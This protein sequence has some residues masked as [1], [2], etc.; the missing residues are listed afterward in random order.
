MSHHLDSPKARQD[1]RLDISDVYI[2]DGDAGTV[3][4]MNVNPLSGSGGFHPE[5]RYEFRIDTDGD[6]IEDRTYVFTF[7]E[8]G[9]DGQQEF[10]AF[11]TDGA[12][13][14]RRD[15]DGE[16]FA[17]GFTGQVIDG[18]NGAR[19]WAGRAADPF[20]MNGAVIGAVQEC[21]THGTPLDLD[22]IDYD[23]AENLFAGTNVQAIVVE[24]PDG[25]FGVPE[26][27]F[28][29]TTALA[30]DAGGWIQI[31]RCAIPFV[32]SFFCADEPERA[33]QYN[34]GHPSTDRSEWGELV[35]DRVSRVV[36]A[37]GN[38][39]D[40]GG[41][42]RRVVETLFPDVLRYRPGS[43]ANF[44]FAG[45]NGRGLTE[46]VPEVMFSLVL[47]KAVPLGIDAGASTGAP[48]AEFP[49][50]APPL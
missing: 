6:A 34:L 38:T 50:L 22:K 37:A 40:P 3:L 36:A 18:A 11:R 5:A 42:A 26:I 25:S 29:A 15:D 48:R 47:D 43:P 4:V 41:H 27:G 28:W 8:C 21:C 16:L 35:S 7:S 20:F 31:N 23:G 24:I 30:T 14:R 10:R 17:H 49:Y 2:F 45:R 9:D 13:A 44:G 39:A 33:D 32:N 1:P 46:S 12:A 19:V